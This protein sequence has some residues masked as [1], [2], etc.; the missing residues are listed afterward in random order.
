MPA[1]QQPPV[2]SA[3]T[4]ASGHT[5]ARITL[6]THRPGDIGWI[7]HRHGEVYA[8]EY[9]WD[10]TFEAIA[11]EIGADFLRNYDP[12]CERCWIAEVDGARAG[13]VM[14]IRDRERENVARLRVLLVE[15][16]ARGRGVGR[17]LVHQCTEFARSAGY[18]A[19]TLWTSNV[20]TDARRLYE[21]EGYRRME[22]RPH[23]AYGKQMT[24]EVWD[25]ML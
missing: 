14:L 18:A 16:N 9:D 24:G 17:M 2:A 4:G 15:P 11:A 13:S 10:G 25:L 22:M 20:L 5:A 21:Q 8:R 7:I 23:N 12:T 6:R 3:T 1:E 19:I